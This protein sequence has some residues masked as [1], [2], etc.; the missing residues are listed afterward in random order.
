MKVTLALDTALANSDHDPILG[1]S[2]QMVHLSLA[3]LHITL[4]IILNIHH[5]QCLMAILTA[6]Y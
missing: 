5:V 1:I 6:K 2:E 4:T 3:L